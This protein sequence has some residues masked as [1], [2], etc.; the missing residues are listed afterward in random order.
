VAT[1]APTVSARMFTHTVVIVLRGH[2]DETGT[3]HLRQL[4]VD[5]MMHRRPRRIV[6]DLAQTT[7]LDPTAV[8]ALIA[9]HDAA[10]DVQVS[11]DLRRP[12][13]GLAAELAGH[14]LT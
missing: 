10:P 12:R 8:G 11:F 2:V 14:G 6:V 9:A 7:G 1:V 13:P 4:L 3:I 5:A